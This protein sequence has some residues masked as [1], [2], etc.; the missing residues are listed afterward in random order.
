MTTL[1]HDVRYAVRTL[2]SRLGFT[3]VAVLTLALG[4]GANSAIFSVVNAV[5]L[6]P[7]PYEDPGQL[8]KINSS[9]ERTGATKTNI[10]PAD[11]M[12]LKRDLTSFEIMASPGWVGFATLT[13][14]DRAERLGNPRVTP[15]FF[16]TLGINP[17][18]GRHFTAEEGL[19]GGHWGAIISHGL[20]QRRFGSD[21]NIIGREILLD[22]NPT[23]VIGVL[24]DSYRHLEE[25]PGRSADVFTLY[26][27]D[28]AT[29]TRTGHFI[30]GIARLKAGVSLEQARAELSTVASRQEQEYPENVGK[31]ATAYPLTGEI[32][33][34]SQTMLLVLLGA[35]G[36]VLLIACANIA[37][38]L[39]ASGAAR[40]KEL[41]IRAAL[42]A[43]RGRLV[44]QLLT[45]SLMLGLVGG[46]AGLLL[47]IWATRFLSTL[48]AQTLPRADQIAVD[49]TVLA[50]R[51]GEG[52]GGGR[53]GRGGA[54]VHDWK[55]GRRGCVRL[56]GAASS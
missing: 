21:P 52:G 47:A 7:L 56:D 39:L 31:G 43:G 2:I 15:D 22:A 6:Q 3:L 11:F 26:Q 4:I 9:R 14:G 27:F 12:D 13:G 49:G 50:F 38:L 46:T 36:L 23:T 48:S 17:I 1:L 32:V 35:V 53:V 10:S 20:W 29:E 41:G 30:R 5:L 54:R 42:G 45:E 28:P 19:P 55:G 37:N 51:A 34:A 24:P 18:L 33:G 25:Y 8:V 16:R 44:R 40:H